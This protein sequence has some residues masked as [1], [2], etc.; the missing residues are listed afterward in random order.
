MAC[1]NY[2]DFHSK[3]PGWFLQENAK[4]FKACSLSPV[5]E[6]EIKSRTELGLR[7]VFFPYVISQCSSDENVPV[8][9]KK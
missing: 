4:A 8:S 2:S 6:L 3:P 7:L 5:R 1:L 9:Q